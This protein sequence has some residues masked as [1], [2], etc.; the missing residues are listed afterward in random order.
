MVKLYGVDDSVFVTYDLK[1][2][3]MKLCFIF[4]FLLWMTI[5]MYVL[6]SLVTKIVKAR[7][8]IKNLCKINYY[9]YINKKLT[10]YS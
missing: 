8:T 5:F 6:N 7:Q 2:S 9:T 3:I 4:F 1:L 10:I